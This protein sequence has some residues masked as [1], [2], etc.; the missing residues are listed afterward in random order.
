LLK[1]AMKEWLPEK[2][3]ARR[4]KGFGI[5]L[6]KWL[7]SWPRPSDKEVSAAGG[8]LFQTD[9]FDEHWGRHVRRET[10]ERLLLF[11]WLSFIYHAQN[12]DQNQTREARAEEVPAIA[13]Q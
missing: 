6:A 5:P 2:T 12:Q 3:L 9:A 7:R 4:K 8:A 11:T 10:D 13:V 1:Q